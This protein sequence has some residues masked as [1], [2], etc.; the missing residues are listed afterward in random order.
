MATEISIRTSARVSTGGKKE[1]KEKGFQDGIILDQYGHLAEVSAANIFMVKNNKLLT[2]SL[3]L[4][5]LNGITRDSII[6]LARRELCLVVGDNLI[7][8]TFLPI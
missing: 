3:A 2:P 7:E 8:Y 6:A 1:A 5:I 4:P